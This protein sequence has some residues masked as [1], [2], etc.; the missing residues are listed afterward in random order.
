MIIKELTRKKGSG[1]LVRYILRYTLD[2]KKQITASG[3]PFIIRHNI[4]SRSIE[5]YIKEFQQNEVNRVYKR[6]DQTVIH[7][8]ILSWSPEDAI[9]ITDAKLKAIAKEYVR[10]RGSNNLYVGTKHTDRQHIHLHIAVSGS[11]LNG[12]SSRMSKQ[13]FAGLKCT[14]DAYQKEHF[15][16][17]VH[18][19]PLHGRSAALKTA[20][21][22][23][24][25]D[26]R[27]GR[28]SQ[29]EA[30]VRSLNTA[31]SRAKSIEDFLAE[32]RSLGHQPYYR[33]GQL[34]GIKYSGDRKFRFRSL[35]YSQEK[36]AQLNAIPDREEKQLAS[37]RDI[38]GRSRSSGRSMGQKQGR[39]RE[40][41]NGRDNE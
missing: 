13:A 37:L 39:E 26:R 29:K 19:L 17:L 34:T 3:K 15:S 33:A 32:L 14:L 10:L 41:D 40:T 28:I 27:H 12:R 11:Q 5:G 1:Q 2:E 8:T 21:K 7:H 35:G 36:M 20:N 30:L 4:R 23:P 25:I 24:R 22:V 18:S 16:E 6:K 9:H 38:R 31:Y